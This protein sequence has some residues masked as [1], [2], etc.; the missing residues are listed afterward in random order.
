[1]S[2]SE[3]P[4]DGMSPS[5]DDDLRRVLHRLDGRGYKAYKEIKGRWTFPR[6]DL[7]VDHVQGDPFAA[8]SRVRVRLAGSVTE[9]TPD[10][11][12][13][14]PRAVGTGC[15]L[16]RRFAAEA[17]RSG[18]RGR[19]G[20]GAT[21]SGRSGEIRI[22][23]P[24]QEVIPNTAVIVDPDGGVEARFRVGLPARG[25]RILAGEAARLLLEA[26]P[27]LVEAALVAEAHE[28]G[29]LELHAETNEDAER[30]RRGLAGRD[31]VAFVADGARLPRRTGVDDRP[32]EGEGVV[33]FRSPDGLRVS[34]DLPNAG[35]VTGMGIP[36]G[37]TLIVGGG[38]HGKSTLLRAIERGV[39][40]HRPG[41]GRE[42]VVTDP[43]AMKIRAEDGRSVRSVD[44]S[45]FIGDLPGGAG[46]RRFS[47]PNASGSTSQAAAIVEAM[48]AG[49]GVLLIDEDT[50][51]TNFMIR[52]RRMQALVPR[53]REPIVPFI[54]RVRELS[55]AAGI[56]SVIVLGGSGD[57]LD[58]ADLV[59]AMTDFVPTDLTDE[60]R[61]VARR[62]PTGRRPETPGPLKALPPRRPIPGSIDP[63]RGRRP[64]SVKVQGTKS[65]E[66]GIHEIDLTA[67]E[68]LVSAAQTRAVSE[69]ILLARDRFVDGKRT[70][71]EILQALE[72][73]LEKEGLDALGT[74]YDGELALFRR[75]ELAQ[76]LNRLR[77]LE[78]G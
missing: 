8:P 76:A 51:A 32:L 42:R 60:A 65:I 15:L 48:E 33:P 30:L 49:A 26:V 19:G 38:Y 11:C 17:R 13:A 46:T 23:A 58:V 63:S 37:V 64:V 72:E 52:D 71:P 24:G 69:A 29:T 18:G 54:D 55:E 27:A 34:F 16:A 57:Y 41:D 36:R 35:K 56:S 5:T 10:V 45:A 43:S 20:N 61:E 12:R 21:G 31:L 40:N 47:T 3:A 14:G 25:R 1:M 78:V 9:L 53:D 62:H 70:L 74:P 59:V 75:F 66:F 50:A 39:Y 73:V 68:Q 4:F 2:P 44:I 22:E 28:G 7:F 6:F 67:V 77:P